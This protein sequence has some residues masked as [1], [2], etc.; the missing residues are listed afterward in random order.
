MDSTESVDVLETAGK[1]RPITC[2]FSTAATISGLGMSS[3]WRAARDG[4]LQTVKFGR[5]TLVRM[6][7]LE[8]LLTPA[9][10]AA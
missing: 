6:D 7:S 3:L 2:T 10:D 8:K 1:P 4:R 9:G 5:R